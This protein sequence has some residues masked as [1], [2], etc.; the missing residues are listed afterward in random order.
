[1]SGPGHAFDSIRARTLALVEA[2]GV[3]PAGD[4]EWVRR[5]AEQA[6]LEYQREAQLGRRRSLHRPVDVVERVVRSVSDL[7][8]LTDLL[9][10]TDVEEVFVEGSRV[11]YLEAGGRL[12]LLEEPTTVEENT[13]MVERLLAE[14]DRRLDASSPIV[15]ARVLGGTARLSA[16]IPPVSDH[17]SVTL[18][19]YALRK[20]T[21]PSLVELGSLSRAAASF[22]ELAMRT[23]ASIVVSGPPGAGKT[24]LLSALLNGVPATHCLRCCEEVRELNVPLVHGSF[25]EARPPAL[26]GSGA[27]TLRQLVK[28]VLAMRP[29]RI[30]VGEVRGAEAFELTRAV[31]A[32][33]GFACTVHANSARQALNALVNAAL[34]AGENV[35]EVVVRRVFA[36]AIDLVVHLDREGHVEADRSPLRRVT[37][38]VALS[39]SLGDDFTTESLFV[40]DDIAAPMRWSGA[41]PPGDLA[42]VLERGLPSGAALVDML[43]GRAV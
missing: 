14:T 2:E 33:C 6:V 36:S 11:T 29:D 40:R 13:R 41:L 16:V 12:R 10:R 27:V 5:L 31:N 43:E 21:L 8:P 4:R 9:A 18:R 25:Y 42:V 39:P 22:L 20:E 23:R 26:D 3:D 24:S 35:T 34:M 28:V 19:R 37:E 32:G 30:V 38:I 17:L 15:Q 7:G 1:M